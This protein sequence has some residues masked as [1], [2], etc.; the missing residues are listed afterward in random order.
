[1]I[2]GGDFNEES[3]GMPISNVME[4]AFIDLYTLMKMQDGLY[5]KNMRDNYP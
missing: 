5:S 2:L 3:E 1:M 4:A